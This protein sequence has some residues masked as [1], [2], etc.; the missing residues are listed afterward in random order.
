MIRR[1]FVRSI[2][3]SGSV[4]AVE[5]TTISTPRL[6]G[7]N[8]QSL[9][10]TTLVRPGTMVRAGDLVV[11]FDRQDQLKSAL[12]RRVELQRSR[13]ANQEEAGRGRRGAGARTTAS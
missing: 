8:N 12:D 13:T 11:E 10:I 2:R 5:A 9:V 7:Q 1:D 6:A 3:L 4:E